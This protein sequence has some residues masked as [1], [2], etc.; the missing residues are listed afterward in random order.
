[1]VHEIGHNLG[2]GHDFEEDGS[3]RTTEEGQLPCTDVGGYMDYG[4]NPNEWSPCSMEDMR[5][6]I[7]S[8][9]AHLPQNQLC[10]SPASSSG[11]LSAFVR[12][13]AQQT[14]KS[15]CQDLWRSEECL[16]DS[17]SRNWWMSVNCLGSCGYCSQQDG[18]MPCKDF[19]VKT[20]CG[21][22]RSRGNCVGQS[23]K[24]KKTRLR[25]RK[26]CQICQ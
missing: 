8:S 23:R 12:S 22:K 25:C 11:N 6:Y 1:M 21:R 2:M 5:R 4:Q 16:V 3:P 19:D 10:L 13:P 15:E 24:A 18:T 9:S 14:V 17:C 7:L 26:T 20:D